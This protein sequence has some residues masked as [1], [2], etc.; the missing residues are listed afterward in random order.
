MV[1]HR[2]DSIIEGRIQDLKDE[3]AS[4][5]YQVIKAYRLG[6]SIDELYPGH[7][8]WYQQTMEKLEQLEIVQAREI[9]AKKELEGGGKTKKE[10]EET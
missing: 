9:A 5:D 7:V 4:K 8:L 2:E 3:I 10:D 1:T 6:V